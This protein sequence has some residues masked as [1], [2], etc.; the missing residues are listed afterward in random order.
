MAAF[1]DLIGQSQAV[2]LL[3]RAIAQNRVAPAYLF[4]GAPGVGRSLAA[5]HFAGLLLAP[6]D[7]TNQ[8][9]KNSSARVQQSNHPDLLW[10]EPTYLHQGKRLSATEAAE[11]GVKRKSPPEIRLEQVREVARFLGRPPLEAPRSVV[12][13]EDAETMAEAAANG[14]LKTLEE[15][16]RA[17]LILI[18]PSPESLLPTLV[19]RCQRIPF[20]RLNQAAIAQ[21]L[22][23]TGNGE[24]LQ[25]PEV[26][27]LAQGSPGEAIAQWQ[28]IQ[29]IPPELLTA[30]T[31]PPQSLRTAL[32]LARQIAQSLDTESQLWLL[33]YLQY[34][35]WETQ[36][37]V[38]YLHHLEKAR[39]YLLQYV[40]PRLVWEVTFLGMKGDNDHF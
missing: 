35:Y 11:Q 28:Q 15:P 30:V 32:D 17:T 18:A 31:Q 16:G 33:D 10:V 39:R 7:Q 6:L 2:E 37:Q 27:A 22:I 24:I 23:Q 12:V 26:I 38:A 20:R 13:L 9:S 34:H 14:L 4:A 25:H 1:L 5:R 40:Q 8:P 3:S 29:A 36:R 19:S 21:V